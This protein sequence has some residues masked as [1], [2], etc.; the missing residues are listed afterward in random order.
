VLLCLFTMLATLKRQAPPPQQAPVSLPKSAV[1]PGTP[2]SAAET[3]ADITE[4]EEKKVIAKPDPR[5]LMSPADLHAHRAYAAALQSHALSA[6]KGKKGSG[7]G[8]RFDGGTGTGP[9]IKT[10]LATFAGMTS[11]AG[12]TLYQ[13]IDIYSDA[14]YGILNLA[15]WTSFQALF[16][17]YRISQVRCHYVP[18][19]ANKVE[20]AVNTNGRP[21]CIAFDPDSNAAPSSVGSLW[22]NASA[23]IFSCQLPHKTRWTNTDKRWFD[24]QDSAN[25]LVPQCAIKIA[26]DSSLGVSIPLGNLYIEYMVE[27]RARL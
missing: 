13:A 14:T 10:R 12:S 18:F 26:G 1:Q 2:S 19:T 11:A 22:S 17:Q 25:P 5:T 4:D 20:A 21:L 15:E 27:L 6:K 9:T 8:G 3:W 16:R 7:G 24:A 23:T